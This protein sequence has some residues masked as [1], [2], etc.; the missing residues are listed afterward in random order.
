ML[1]HQ[2]TIV[3]TNLHGSL[4]LQRRCHAP[5]PRLEALLVLH[6]CVF[7]EYQKEQA[8]IMWCLC[9]AKVVQSPAA[10]ARLLPLI[11]CLCC[12]CFDKTYLV[13]RPS[14]LLACLMQSLCWPEHAH[15]IHPLLLPVVFSRVSLICLGRL[16]SFAVSVVTWHILRGLNRSSRVQHVFRLLPSWSESDRL[17]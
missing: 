15:H 1:F 16:L 4:V 13:I 3:F 10:K 5:C 8:D 2:F 6:S 11:T 17:V 14:R 12:W 7:V 9:T